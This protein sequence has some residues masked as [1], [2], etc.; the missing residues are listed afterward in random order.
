MEL[1]DEELYKYISDSM[2]KNGKIIR[3]VKCCYNCENRKFGNGC[4]S[5]GKREII[6]SDS[7]CNA[8][9]ERIE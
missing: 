5:S 7:F 6:T 9:K 2:T 4:Y 8:Y 3:K 1:I